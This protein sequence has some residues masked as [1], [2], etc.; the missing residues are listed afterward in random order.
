M[1]VSGGCGVKHVVQRT[2]QESPPA[3]VTV[4]LQWESDTPSSDAVQ[5]TLGCIDMVRFSLH[6]VCSNT[7]SGPLQYPRL[8]TRRT[9]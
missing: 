6:D 4:E 8:S 5:E 9:V 7:Q 1:H 2:L 3:V